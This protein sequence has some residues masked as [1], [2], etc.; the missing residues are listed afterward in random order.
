MIVDLDSASFSYYCG[1]FFCCIVFG[2]IPLIFSVN[3]TSSTGISINWIYLITG[4]SIFVGTL[5][6]LNA[7]FRKKADRIILEP[8]KF[9]IVYKNRKPFEVKRSEMKNVSLRSTVNPI[10]ESNNLTG[11]AYCKFVISYIDGKKKKIS[12]VD[13]PRRN[14]YT[15]FREIKQYI[16]KHYPT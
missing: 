12:F 5:V 3:I 14:R 1:S 16:R 4:V 9:S 13:L 8:E 11:S 6:L 15:I 7:I 2:I 10:L